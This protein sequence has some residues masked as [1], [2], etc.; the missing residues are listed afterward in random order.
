MEQQTLGQWLEG[1]DAPALMQAGRLL[2]ITANREKQSLVIALQLD[3][4]LPLEE[5]RPVQQQIAQRLGL[6]KCTIQPKYT[7]DLFDFEG[8]MELVEVIKPRCPMIDG[9]LDDCEISQQGLEQVT[10]TLKKGGAQVLQSTGV[11]RL[12]EGAICSMFSFSPKIVYDGL[13]ERPAEEIDAQREAELAALQQQ[14]FAQQESVRKESEAKKAKAGEACGQSDTVSFDIS[15]LLWKSGEVQMV[16]GKP[17]TEHPLPMSE[18]NEYTREVT[19]WGEVFQVESKEVGKDKG[20]LAFDFAFTDYTN[21]LKMHLFGRPEKVKMYEEIKKGTCLLVSGKMVY[22]EFQKDYVLEPK[23]VGIVQKRTRQDNALEKRTELHLHTNM[24]AMDAISAPAKMVR[25]AYDWGWK[26]LALTDHGVVQ[27]FPEAMYEVDAIRKSGG[28]FKLIYGCEAYVINDFVSVVRDPVAYPLNDMTVV[29]DFE[30]TGLSS[31]KDEIIEI[32]AVKLQNGQEIDRFSAFVKPNQTISP[33]ITQITGIT[34]QMVAD[35][36]PIEE[37]LPAFL[38]FVGDC[39]MVAH[40]ADFDMGFLYAAQ[41]RMGIEK[42]HPALDTV[43]LCRILFPEL[44]NHK[45]NTVAEHLELGDFNHHRACDDAA[46]LAKIYH[47]CIGILAERDIAD[48][49][50]INAAI[51]GRVTEENLRDYH[52]YHEILLVKNATGLKNLYRL[53]SMAHTKYFYKKPLIPRSLLMQ[54]REGLIVGSACEAGWLYQSMLKN[55]PYG[56][57]CNIAKFYDYLEIQPLCNNS[58]M[59]RS[60]QVGSKAELAQLNKRIV[61]LGEKLHIP[62]VA[63]CDVHFMN[64]EDGIYRKVLLAG[65]KF[66]DFNQQADL[67]LRTTEEMLKEFDYLGEAKAKEVVITNPN[68]IAQMVDADVRAIPKGVYTP[69]MEGSDEELREITTRRAHALYG[70][71]LPQI[72]QERLD[73]ELDSI[74]N[75]GFSVLYMIAQKLIAKSN[76]WG[77]VV[78]SRGSVGSSFVATMAGISEVNPIAPHYVCPHCHYSEFFTHGEVGSGFDLPDKVCPQCGTVMDHDGHDI[79]FETF[80]GFFGDKQ[81]DIDLNFSGDVQNQIHRYTE[82]LFGK[83]NVFKAGTISTVAEKTAFGFSKAYAEA[84]GVGMNNAELARLASGCDGVKRTT[85]QHPGGMVVVPDRYDIE[86]FCPYQYPAD[87]KDKGV[88]TTHFDFRSMHD[89]LLKLDLLGHDVPTMYHDFGEITGVDILQ[90]PT[91]D[92]KVYELFTSPAPLGVTKEAIHC[93]TGTLGLPEMGTDFVIGMLMDAQPKTFS[94]LLQISGLSHGTG[95]WLGNAQELIKSGQCT[96][97]SVIGTRDSIMVTL[98]TKYG[99]E[100]KMAFDIMEI[101]RKGKAKKLLTQAH[102]DAMKACNVPQWYVDS[103]YKIQYMFPKAHAAAYVTTAVKLGWFKIYYPQAFYAV[104]FTRKIED[105]DI[106]AAMEG[107]ESIEARLAE[108]REKGNAMTVKEGDMY[109]SLQMMNEMYARGIRFLPIDL[110]KSHPTQYRV[111]GENVRLPFTAMKGIGASAAMAFAEAVKEGDFCSVEELAAKPGV[112]KTIIESLR[113]V[114]AL[115]DL[116]ESSQMTL[117]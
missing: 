35:A 34:N 9:L 96:I 52:Y 56:T 97:S 94:D 57:L 79:P 100:N 71:P 50:E 41:K 103:C 105:L 27:A 73:K 82:E 69:E 47:R 13:L 37:V 117:F 61:E 45:L 112:G 38:A 101:T 40:N 99:L 14:V 74:I 21:S 29:F 65:Q 111:E 102:L 51:T 104:F 75:N 28:E 62:V 63:T 8:F 11:T 36:K 64:R 95:V 39:P 72:V 83:E 16:A 87:S 91:N 1:L 86:D 33:K 67:Y 92:P 89:T 44:K 77:Y 30:T 116:P 12:L 3:A 32:G 15:D 24:S 46:V 59:I 2:K 58:F 113:E 85:G 19:V 48:L 66:S 84:V 20:F 107:K 10:V 109:Q 26:S 106:A 42:I 55:V 54:Y 23:S 5:M 80:L 49:A 90:V 31:N 78:G 18:V 70:D 93:P 53:V 6:Q 43:E 98:I 68:A 60:G 4:R 115:K 22:S 81:P 110:Y 17:I 88:F 108:L 76:A 114:G 7:P 25:Q